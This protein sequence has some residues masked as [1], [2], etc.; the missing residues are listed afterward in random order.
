MRSI[1]V[2]AA[3]LLLVT[4][5]FAH[6]ERREDSPVR[7][8]PVPSLSRVNPKFLVVCKASS[9]P[10]R[11]EHKDIHY[12]LKTTSGQ[13]LAQAQAEETAW[14][15]NSKLF[16]KCRFEHIQE[17]VNAA[18][19]DT[20]IFI[21]PG[22][23]REEPSRAAP[24][25]TSGDLE[26][27]AYSYAY[28]VANPN[29]ANLIA[30]LG[31]KNIT[32]EGTGLAPE[33]VLID[34]G[35]VKDIG[36]RCDQC[37]GFIVRNL[38][39]RDANEHGVYVLYSDGYI[40]DRVRGSYNKEYSLF[41]YA[42]DN[43]LYTDCI[44]EGG[45][46]S[47]LY[48]GANPDTSPRFAAEVRNTIMRHSALGFSGTQGTS[49]WMHDNDV[50]DNAIGLSFDTENDHQNFPQR[51]SLIENNLLHDNNFDIYAADSDVPAR[52]PAYDFFRY[53]VG[54]GMWLIGG[55]DNII[56]NNIVWNNIRFGFIIAGNALEQPM[57]AQIFRNA[58]TGNKMGVDPLGNL[59]PN[60]TA[61][62]PGGD[63]APGGSDFFWD[64][65]GNDNCWG[66]QD[67][68]SG[69]ITTDPPNTGHPTGL[70]GPC[71][72]INV[73]A[74]VIPPALKA[75]L[76]LSCSMDSSDPPHTL[77]AVYP[78]PW[79]QT[80]DSGYLNGGELECGN[81]VIDLGEDCDKSAYSAWG[82][83][84]PSE[85]CDTLGHGPGTL[86]CTTTPRACTWDTSGCAANTCAEYGASR[87]RLKNVLGA[88]GDDELVFTAK[89]F[90]GATFDPTTEDLSF[91][92]R[93]DDG[94][95]VSATIPGGSP[96]YTAG[97][98]AIT[99]S[100]PSGT[101]GGITSVSL[102]A[103]TTFPTSFRA[104]VRIRAGVGAA[105]GARTG[106]AV[107]RIGNDCWSDTTPCSGSGSNVT[108]RGKSAP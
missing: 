1:T 94:L 86:D 67:P 80:N 76:L 97:P 28:H 46:D 3:L 20:D 39:Q 59:A 19:D 88:S 33:D 2:A 40:F 8:G 104:Q 56:R 42:S 101:H 37:T 90:P 78:C 91:V 24:T 82:A 71:P 47:G 29:D 74:V 4:N 95:V 43:G 103:T 79:G 12:R 108:C 48:I 64:E 96:G 9:K 66:P 62:P 89:N 105:A 99:F 13:A 10:T 6:R 65:T 5:A 15:R 36:I 83:F 7:P 51:K 11:A 18:G 52:G 58:V 27:G 44:A 68:G 22:V 93:D 17:A 50:Y 14:H 84:I 35:F 75:S 16:K 77:D 98:T 55:E 32:L 26:D 34:N 100:D 87:T 53:P 31:K 92:F 57:P 70:P 60:H 63:Y 107:L 54:T 41:S 49:I 72:S 61:F 45:G 38:W 30:I 81:G 25:S 21:L 23:Y 85:T 69:P 106:T 102:R 73:G